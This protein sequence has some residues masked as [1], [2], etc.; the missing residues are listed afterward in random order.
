MVRIPAHAGE[1]TA[2]W[3]TEVLKQ[4]GVLAGRVVSVA[5]ERIGEGIGL[6]A[7]LTR[8]HL[9]HAGAENL[10]P[11]LVAKTAARNENRGL[12]QLMD[13]YRREVNFYNRIS[14]DSPFRVP[15]S[16]FAA[17][18][19]DSADFVILMEDLGD[20]APNDQLTGSSEKEALDR[21]VPISRLHARY[22]NLVDR[23][24]YDWMYPIQTPEEAV[25]IR[26]LIYMPSLALAT[27][28]F[29]EHFDE[30]TETLCRR[31]G[32]QYVELLS[33]LTS[34][35]TFCHGDF[36]QDNFIYTASGEAVIMDW[37][38]SGFANPAFD[39]SYFLCQSLQVDLR[40]EIDHEIFVRYID[41]LKEEG[42]QD[43][44]HTSAWN[45]YRVFSLFCLVYPLSACGTLDLS[46]DRGKALATCMLERN[47]AVIDDLHCADLLK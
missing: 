29:P 2:D 42:I 21:V 22:W 1:I 5:E 26:D 46:N 24:E 6:L 23:P 39:L 18:D 3:L 37:Q 20:V 28:K 47:L 25:K 15:K 35:R 9:E 44:D 17:I 13:F 11:T 45:D 16:Y 4:Q 43:Y 31:V 30:A 10:P 14:A 33:N 12:A 8:L 19:E 38:I 7:E 32:E 27:E 41:A 40:R 34:P 36:R